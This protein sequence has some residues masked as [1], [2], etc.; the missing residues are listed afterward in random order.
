MWEFGKEKK[1]LEKRDCREKEILER[2]NSR[3]RKKLRNL[4]EGV[5]KKEDPQG[6]FKKEDPQERR[7]TQEGRTSNKKDYSRRTIPKARAF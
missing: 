6:A 3:E 1:I 5:F 7:S 2:R 4:E